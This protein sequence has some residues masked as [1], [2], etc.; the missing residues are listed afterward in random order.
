MFIRHI[1][2]IALLL[3]LA[4]P[5]GVSA[6]V[7]MPDT[8]LH[9]PKPVEISYYDQDSFDRPTLIE[10]IIKYFNNTNKVTAPKKFDFS[11]LGGPYYS[12]DTKF[13]VGVVAAGLYRKNL[14]D[15]INPAGQVNLYGSLSITKY[16]KVGI[17]GSQYFGNRSPW[18]SYDVSFESM[19]DKFWGIGYAQCSD[20]ANETRY[21]RWHA[22]LEASVLF[23]LLGD[24]F[25]IGPRILLDYLDGK[26]ITRPDLWHNQKW[27]T[28]SDGIGF[29]IVYDSRDNEF[30]AYRGIN[31]RLD[32]MFAPR[33]LG[34]K[35]AFSFTELNFNYYVPTWK[36]CILATRFHTRCTYGN[37]PWG[38]M[39]KLGGNVSMRGYWEGR[40]NDKCAADLT[41]ELRQHVW[42]RIGVVAWGG[43]GEIF[44]R[45]EEIFKGHALW[46][47][48]IGMRW[49]FKHRVNVRLDY[50]FGQHQQGM[51]FSI[52]EAF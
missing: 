48:G 38:L 25:Y 2:R 15:T 30:N 44:P 12:S 4:L 24:N 5:L 27:K 6:Q 3:T 10:K 18:I 16:F 19:P 28:F 21:K 26:H 29:T 32:Q 13:G 36:G 40:Y 42:K 31:F 33:F 39:S 45:L 8:I 51:I 22:S 37:T 23:R 47:A 52:N 43:V 17:D 35:Y 1:K 46:N 7:A 20:D 34:N 49:E 9:K 50:G 41:I 14:A 11:I